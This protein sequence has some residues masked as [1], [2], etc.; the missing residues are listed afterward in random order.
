MV[1]QRRPTPKALTSL[2]WASVL[3]S[4]AHALSSA[5]I[6]Q[7]EADVPS[8]GGRKTQGDYR[9]A[10]LGS[11]GTHTRGGAERQREGPVSGA[12]SG[13][14]LFPHVLSLPGGQHLLLMPASLL[15][16]FGSR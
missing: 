12:Q 15:C 1:A 8:R 4:A 2:I 3:V 7:I 9:K 10:A 13:A 16:S 6:Y 5:G 14:R 11:S